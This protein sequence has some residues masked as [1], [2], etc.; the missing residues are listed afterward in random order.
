MECQLQICKAYCLT[1]S[2]KKSCFFLKCFKFVGANVL[3]D[4]NRPAMSKHQ[5]LDHWPTPEFVRNIVSFIGFVQFCS[6]FIFYFEICK[7]LLWEIMQHEYTSCVGDLW[8]PA[9]AAAVAFDELCH[10]I[11]HNPCLFCFDHK[12][13]TILR[14]DFSSQGFG[15]V[16][17]QTDDNNASLQLV[18]QYMS[19]NWFC[20]MTSTSKSTLHPIAFGSWLTRGNESH[21][22]LFLGEIFAGD[23]AMGKCCHMLFGHC[24]V[25]IT[26]CYAAWFLL[27]YD[28]GNQAVQ[29]LQMRI[30]G[31][32]VD[33]LHWAIDYLANANY[34]SRLD[35]DLC[36]DPTFKDY[37]WLVSTLR[38][39]ST[40]PSDL[41]ILLRNMPYYRGLWIKVDPPTLATDDKEHQRLLAYSF[42]HSH[43]AISTHLSNRPIQFRNFGNFLPPNLGHC[44]CYNNKFPAYALSV[45][46]LN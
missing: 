20:F 2:L 30:M 10:C 44:V 40:S 18:A 39:Q 8:T 23:W 4:G 26:D 42:L 17:C 19:V 38:S 32:D 12:K 1:L 15:Y 5:L 41:P 37:I 21:L 6:A 14:T 24:F 13:L 45:T 35:S 31:W 46:Q 36:Y 3:P 29:H 34:W 25:W 22:H 7:K 33:I 43:S 16:V 28:S 9:A 27:L 11:L